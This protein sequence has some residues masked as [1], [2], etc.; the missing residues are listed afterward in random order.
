VYNRAKKPTSAMDE[1]DESWAEQCRQPF[2]EALQQRMPDAENP[3]TN[4]GTA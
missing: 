1:K 3:T 2:I 4:G